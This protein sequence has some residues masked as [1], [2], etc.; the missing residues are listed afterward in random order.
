[1]PYGKRNYKKVARKSSKKTRVKIYLQAGGLSAKVKK[2]VKSTIARN[3]ENK[4]FV[5]DVY[6]NAICPGTGFDSTSTNSGLT[7]SGSIIPT[8]SP[9]VAVDQRI[10]NKIRVRQLQIR[11]HLQSQPVNPTNNSVEGLPFY[12]RVV[13]YNRKDSKTNNTNNTILDL[14]GSS[15]SFTGA[16]S[17]LLYNYNKDTFNIIKSQ[18]FKMQ[19]IQRLTGA[20]V[21]SDCQVANGFASHILRSFNIKCPKVLVYDDVTAQPN[22]RIFCAIGVVNGDGSSIQP[23]VGGYRLRVSMDSHLVYEDA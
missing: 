18:T 13:F 6:F 7:T 12:V 14:G 4:H 21:S 1:M 22:A 2:Y 3:I 9:G 10:G 15:T 20:G 19:P 23:A 5:K 17:S 11:M 8:I 16:T